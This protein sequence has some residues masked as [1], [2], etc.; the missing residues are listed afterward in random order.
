MIVGAGAK[1]P[2]VLLVKSFF[3][4]ATVRA[5]KRADHSVDVL[6]GNK[7]RRVQQERQD[8]APR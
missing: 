6:V 5:D 2:E 3:K 4:D 8:H 7:L 1:D